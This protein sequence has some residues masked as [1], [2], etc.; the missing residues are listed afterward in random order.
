MYFGSLTLPQLW[1]R[2]LWLSWAP[3]K[4]IKGG[5]FSDPIS[6]LA[7]LSFRKS[8]KKIEVPSYNSSRAIAKM[9]MGDPLSPPPSMGDRVNMNM[10]MDFWQNALDV[11]LIS[12]EIQKLKQLL[13]EL[14][15]IWNHP[16]WL[17]RVKQ[18]K[19]YVLSFQSGNYELSNQIWVRLS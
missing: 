6:A 16:E 5:V 17:L 19:R 9:L 11:F 8:K 12:R 18:M 2:I 1:H 15:Q 7:Q 3:P 4:E 13:F 14:V 10:Y